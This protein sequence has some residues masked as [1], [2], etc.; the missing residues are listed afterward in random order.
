MSI[1]A[2]RIYVIMFLGTCVHAFVN[3]DEAEKEIKERNK[4]VGKGFT[5]E[6]C[7]LQFPKE[8]NLEKYDFETIG[9][10]S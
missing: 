3:E 9:F 4:K 2:K 7:H 6:V 8:K 1:V 10:E 5:L